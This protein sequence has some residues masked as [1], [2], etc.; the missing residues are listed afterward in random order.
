MFL[1]LPVNHPLRPLYRFLGGLT[2]L[3]VLGYGVV[4]L[5]ASWGHG[6]FAHDS[7]EALGL[8]TNLAF[9]VLSILVGLAVLIAAIIDNNVDQYTFLFGGM[10]FLVAGMAMLVLMQT[11][12][13][14]LN[15]TV[16]KCVA[17]FLMG[18]VMFTAGLY[19]RHG[20]AEVRQV[21]ERRRHAGVENGMRPAT[22]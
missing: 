8:R 18:L 5:F 1:H 22:G 14:V 7:V 17:S 19:T 11:T 16:A 9:S 13:N 12:L 6:V 3:Y 10:V 4:G 2:G 20:P 15:F 21:E